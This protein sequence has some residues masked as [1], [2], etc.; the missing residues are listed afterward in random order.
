MAA[1]ELR[2]THTGSI[3]GLYWIVVKPLLLIGMY[4]VLFGVV[5]QARAGQNQTMAEYVLT[6]LTGLLPWLIFS[7]A[8]SAAAGS[9]TGNISL[10]TK[11]VFPIETLPVSKVLA[12]MCSG[13][14]SLVLLVG[15]LMFVHHVGWTLTLLPLLFLAQTCFTIGVA[16]VISAVSVAIRDTGQILPL[17]LMVWMFLSPVVYTRE[18]VPEALAVI[19]SFNPM[20]YFLESY[21]MILLA[22]QSPA[23]WIWMAVTVIWLA[24]FLSGLACCRFQRHRVRCM[25]ETGGG[26]W[27]DGSLRESLSWRL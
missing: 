9:I 4:S 27:S 1:D 10:V 23:V 14:V 15:F 22:N 16:W 13:L 18:M 6:L 3:I 21:R 26:A 7:E 2:R 25:N 17:A 8:V 20:S 24:M 11:I 5:F 19:F 12:T